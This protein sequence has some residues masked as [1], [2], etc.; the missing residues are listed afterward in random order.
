[1]KIDFIY[2]LLKEKHNIAEATIDGD[3]SDFVIRSNDGQ[4]FTNADFTKSELEEAKA[5]LQAEK[6]ELEAAALAAK[7]TA[8][9]K[10]AALGLTADDLKALGLGNN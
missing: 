10:L 5:K 9:A 8:Q 4:T 2:K 6:A 1:M 3:E 7:E